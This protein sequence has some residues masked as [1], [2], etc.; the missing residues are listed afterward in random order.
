MRQPSYEVSS[1]KVF[2][3][4][5]CSILSSCGVPYPFVGLF[6][7]ILGQIDKPFLAVIAVAPDIFVFY[8]RHLLLFDYGMS[9]ESGL[10]DGFYALIRIGLYLN[11]PAAGRL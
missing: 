1:D 10:K 6:A 8:R 9:V 11:S 3:R 2:L 4:S 7:P 5:D